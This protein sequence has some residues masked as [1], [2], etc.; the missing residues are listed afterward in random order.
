MTGFFIG[1]AIG[2][3]TGITITGWLIIIKHDHKEIE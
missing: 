3:I 2:L 1:M